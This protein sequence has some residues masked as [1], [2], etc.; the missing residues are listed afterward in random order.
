MYIIART[1]AK[2]PTLQHRLDPYAAYK[3]LCGIEVS[4]WSRS[5]SHTAIPEVLCKKCEAHRG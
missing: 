4:T 5:Y 2:R 3:T 1:A